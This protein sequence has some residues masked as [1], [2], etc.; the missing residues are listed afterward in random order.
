MGGRGAT[1][2]ALACTAVLVSG[3]G[4]TVN[5]TATWPGAVLQQAVL[6]SGDFPAG[7]QYRRLEEKPGTP[8]GADGP[9]SMLSRPQGC[10]N[11]LTAVIRRTAERGPGSAAKYAVNYDGARI[12]MTVLSWNLD[13]GMIK[14]EAD[15]CAK[16]EVFF[17]PHSDGIPMSTAPLSGVPDGALA[18]QQTMNLSGTESAGYM[19]FQNVGRRAL[20]GLAFPA[21]NPTI[22]VKA[23]LPQTFLEIFA[24]QADR[25]RAS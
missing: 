11:A 10:A 13:L 3:C 7:V 22:S 17:D 16:F 24:K 19:V 18:Y 20:F 8:D 15:R 12:V 2:G 14:A 25:L 23:S 5:G 21:D 4:A 1:A 6:E 9:G